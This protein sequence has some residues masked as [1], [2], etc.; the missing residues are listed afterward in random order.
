MQPGDPDY[1]TV[2]TRLQTY[3]RARAAAGPVDNG[4]PIWDWAYMGL[5]LAE[6]YLATGDVNV[7]PGINS[8]TLK[9]AVSQ[10]INGTF[11]HSASVLRPDGSGRRMGI[12][13]GPVNAVGIVANMAIVMG[14]KALLAGGQSINPEIDGAIQRGSDFFAFYVNKGPIP[15]GEHEPFCP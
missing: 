3:A 4:L 1:T 5:F 15:Y 11:G 12:G 9:L 2:Q 8:Y 13:Y 6:Y 10:S 14:K 7:L